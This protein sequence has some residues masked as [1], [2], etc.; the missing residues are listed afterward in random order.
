[1]ARRLT[2]YCALVL[3]ENQRVNLTGAKTPESIVAHVLD[4]LTIVPYAAAPFVDVGSG[5]GFPA[6]P[7]AISTGIPITLIE[8]TAKKARFLERILR[9][10]GLEGRVV[11]E[12]AE[13]AAREEQ[14]RDRF[15]SGTAR[16]VGPVTTAAELL[17]PF[18]AVG[19]C[20]LLQRGALTTG[21]HDA[22]ADA[23]LVLG[24]ELD[25]TVSVGGKRLICLLRKRRATPQ[26]FPRR[27]G[28]PAKRPL[29]A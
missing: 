15:A 27:V 1:M 23:A 28:V 3:S 9:E 10:L 14:L 11:A 12:R 7:V 6:I 5:A 25:E 29:C 26:R 13:A 21:E 8:S 16:A 19:G 22:L 17:M 4:S 18:I 2:H 24:G 20:A